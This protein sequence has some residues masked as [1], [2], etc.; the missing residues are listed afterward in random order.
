[1]GIAGSLLFIAL[2]AVLAFA[3]RIES[4][5][6]LDIHMIG[7]ILMVIG[8]VALALQFVSWRPR[9]PTLAP[10]LPPEEGDRG[11]RFRDAGPPP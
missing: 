5:G 4:V 6:A 10:D 1:M 8:L 3:I 9:R 11:P 2:G 7:W